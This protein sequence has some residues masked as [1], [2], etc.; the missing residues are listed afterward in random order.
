MKSLINDILIESI[1][2]TKEGIFVVDNNGLII[3]V[4]DYVLSYLG[5]SFKEITKKYVWQIDSLRN[6]KESFEDIRDNKKL[7]FRTYHLHKN[8]IQIPV[9]VSATSHKVKN[10][11]Y[12]V[13]YVK[14]IS[15]KL[16]QENKLK[17]FHDMLNN[18]HDM[19][20]IMRLHDGY[21]DYVNQTAIETL[22]YTF[23]E[24]NALG[25]ESFRKPLRGN[26]SFSQHLDELK[27]RGK[28]VD[29]AI[30]TKKDG[31]EIYV[32]ANVKVIQKDGI[33]YNIAIVRDTTARF[34]LENQLK[35]VNKN[36]ENAVE[37]KTAEL[38]KNIAY[39]KSYKL[40]LDESS[41]VSRAD[42]Y[43]NITYVNDKFCEVSGYTKDEALG[44]PHSIVR[45]PESSSEVFK[46]LWQTIRSKKAWKGILQNRGKSQDYWVDISILPILDESDEITEYIAVRHDITKI[47]E[48]KKAL[49]EI[50]NRDTLTGFDNRYKLNADI[51]NSK[52]PALAIINIDNFSQVNDFYG[53]E[54]GDEIIKKLGLEIS[55]AM[56][57][58]CCTLYHLQGDEYV[59]FNADIE[60]EYFTSIIKDI[61]EKISSAPLAIYDEDLVLNFT[62]A[63]SFESWD[64]ILTTADMALKVARKNDIDFLLY[65]EEISLNSEYE[66]NIKW[67]KKIKYALEND[68][69]VPVFQPIVS[70][71]GKERKKYEALVRLEDK[72]KLVSPYFFLEISKKTKHYSQITKTMIQKTFTMFKDQDV[73]FSIN[74]TIQDILNAQ[75]KEY[76]FEMVQSYNLGERVVFEIV[77]SESIQNFQDV[78]GF[79]NEVRRFGCKI[80]IDDFG[81]GYSNFEYLLK[82]KAD[83]IK[84]DGSMIK[85]IDKDTDA[86]I[87]VATIVD[88]AKKM[89]VKTVAE[90]VENEAIYNKVVELGV[91]YSQGYYFCVPKD[92]RKNATS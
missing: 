80:A 24:I 65:S 53:H 2:D 49:D 28:L 59:L 26:E 20:F 23:D 45:H 19:I 30:L 50:V 55:R 66:N 58:N 81:T 8:S 29:Y 38:L 7:E 56:C 9:E 86:Q 85:N 84:I 67:T 16:N 89:G 6:T 25:I 39:L 31:T 12:M 74:L 32:E 27:Q 60:K 5:Y 54:I 91:D 82:I 64:K 76:I 87:V 22:G 70:N 37:E 11:I 62:T 92:L 79:I 69:I 13:A 90:F 10:S 43:G 68:N 72:G 51:K 14:E 18:S 78:I 52:N 46:E 63:I 42:L 41:I 17:L 83:Y 48:Q 21:V 71:F 47:I 88:F 36:L 33:D 44:K 15:A 75:I 35:E 77:E 40:A 1:K 34:E 57:V 61:V 3:Y 4:N 73:E